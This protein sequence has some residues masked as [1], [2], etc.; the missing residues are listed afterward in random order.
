M[1][2]YCG[3]VRDE[4][5]LKIGLD[6][7][8]KVNDAM[9]SVDVRPS[10]EGYQDLVHALDLRASLLTAK[11]T[12][13]SAIERQESRG[14]HQR[15]DYPEQ[16]PDLKVNFIITLRDGDLATSSVPVPEVPDYL[17]EWEIAGTDVEPVEG[18]LLE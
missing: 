8:A 13:L 18:R 6:K 3:V 14:A 4:K 15:S 2:E 11:A 9:P 16:D 12:I 1:W 7:I 17:K 10:A 5:H